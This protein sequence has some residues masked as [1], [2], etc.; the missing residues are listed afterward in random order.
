MSKISSNVIRLIEEEK[1]EKERVFIT[2]SD[3]LCT[4]T[5]CET[6]GIAKS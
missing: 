1:A 4:L 6:F 2:I 3:M 5:P